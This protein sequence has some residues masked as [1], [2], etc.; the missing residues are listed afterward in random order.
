MGDSYVRPTASL[1]GQQGYNAKLYTNANQK[2]VKIKGGRY[3]GDTKEGKRH[4]KGTYTYSNGQKY[5]GDWKDDM[6]SGQGEEIWPDGRKYFGE[7][8]RDAFHGNGTF[9]WADGT[10]FHGKFKD[11]CPVEGELV[12][13]D[14]GTCYHVIYDGKTPIFSGQRPS[15][16][17][18]KLLEDQSYEQGRGAVENALMNSKSF[19]DVLTRR[20]REQLELH[21]EGEA[22]DIDDVEGALEG[23]KISFD[24]KRRSTEMTRQF[25]TTRDAERKRSQE[26]RRSTE[27]RRSGEAGDK[28]FGAGLAGARGGKLRGSGEIRRS[29]EITRAGSVER[30]SSAGGRRSVE[31]V[32]QEMAQG[33]KGTDFS[34][35]RS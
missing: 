20:L 10:V 21:P 26:G 25:P 9:T 19:I 24:I 23:V 2:R 8:K 17:S 28:S 15:P 6:R 1:S 7:W 31:M 22:L 11:Y 5:Y 18:S 16:I 30:A 12:S 29:G 34:S 27:M 35:R 33:Q 4:G 14:R 13:D 3:D 32:R